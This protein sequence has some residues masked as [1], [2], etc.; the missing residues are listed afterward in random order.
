MIINAIHNKQDR[1]IGFSCLPQYFLDSITIVDCDFCRIGCFDVYIEEF[2]GYSCCGLL[3]FLLFPLSS[4]AGQPQ[5]CDWFLKPEI[6]VVDVILT[7]FSKFR[8]ISSVFALSINFWR[9]ENE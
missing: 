3:R 4:V 6:I 9:Q 7:K 5:Q 8:I 1:Q 2:S